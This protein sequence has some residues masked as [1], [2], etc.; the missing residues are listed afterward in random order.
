LDRRLPEQDLPTLDFG[1]LLAEPDD[2]GS[3]E[4]HRQ[5][6]IV[7]RPQCDNQTTHADPTT[8]LA[9]V[10]ARRFKPQRNMMAVGD[11]R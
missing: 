6:D 10:S 8:S 4:R 2:P 9:T 7:D 11:V 5:L 1:G 3:F